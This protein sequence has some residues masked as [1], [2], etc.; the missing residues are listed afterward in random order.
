MHD[1]TTCSDCGLVLPINWNHQT[2]FSYG[3]SWCESCKNFQTHA[4]GEPAQV[5]SFISNVKNE[6]KKQTKH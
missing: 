1:K 5:L 3:Y 2:N 6:L 4:T